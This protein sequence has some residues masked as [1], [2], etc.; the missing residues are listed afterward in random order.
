MDSTRTRAAQPAVWRL[1]HRWWAAI[2]LAVVPVVFTAAASAAGQLQHLGDTASALV[3]AAGAALSAIIGLLMMRFSR[4]TLAEYGFRTA[5]N[6]SAAWWFLPLPLTVLAALLTQGMHLPGSAVAAYAMLTVAVA[7]N[8]EIWFRGIVLAILRGRST[9]TAI[10]GSAVLFGILHLANLA[11]GQD[12]R[13]SL[14][15]LVF[16]MLFGFVAAE[17][18]VLTGSLWPAIAWHALWDFANYLGG[19]STSPAALGGVAVA[20]AIMVVYAIVLWRRI[21]WGA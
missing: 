1:T 19:N 17:L 3:I 20:C 21:D 8:E 12:L 7:F 18:V 6:V 13:A 10:I 11:S 9:R 4:P 15:Q 14:L 16:A 2:G 5:K